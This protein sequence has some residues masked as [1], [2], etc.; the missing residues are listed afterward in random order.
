[1]LYCYWFC[2]SQSVFLPVSINLLGHMEPDQSNVSLQNFLNNKR[3]QPTSMLRKRN[4]L[5]YLSRKSR[6]MWV[7]SLFSPHGWQ[8]QVRGLQNWASSFLSMSED[9]GV[10]SHPHTNHQHQRL[11]CS[12]T[13]ATWRWREVL[14]KDRMLVM[15][16]EAGSESKLD[17]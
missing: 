16:A 6:D 13:C 1:M 4:F 14:P 9:C 3:Q 2:V 5:D 10:A 7:S 11:E 17:R 15:P 8:L 12:L